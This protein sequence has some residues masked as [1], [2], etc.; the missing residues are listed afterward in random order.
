MSIQNSSLIPVNLSNTK[1]NDDNFNSSNKRDLHDGNI[2]YFTENIKLIEQDVDGGE[3]S[4]D[5][6]SGDE[7]SKSEHFS[8]TENIEH[9]NTITKCPLIIN[10]SFHLAYTSEL[11]NTSNCGWFGC[12]VASALGND[13]QPYIKFGHGGQHPQKFRMIDSATTGNVLNYGESFYIY[14]ETPKTYLHSS[15]SWTNKDRYDSR[16]VKT[17]GH[18]YIHWKGSGWGKYPVR[19]YRKTTYKYVKKYR[20][21]TKFWVYPYSGTG[22]KMGDI[23]HY[24]E[25]VIIGLDGNINGKKLT[26][27]SSSRAYAHSTPGSG[28]GFYFRKPIGTPCN[29]QVPLIINN[30]DY[31]IKK[32]TIRCDD[33]FDMYI[34]GRKYSGSGWKNTFTF[35]D[36]VLAN[37]NNGFNI[38]FRCYN[39]GGPAGLIACIELNNGSVYFTD[40]TWDAAVD[41]KNPNFFLNN[42]NNYGYGKEWGPPNVIG[43]NQKKELTWDGNKSTSRDSSFVD[44]KFSPF[45]KWIWAGKCFNKGYVYLKKTIGEPPKNTARCRHN[46]TFGEALCYLEK[47]PDL[48]KAF[49]PKDGSYNINDMVDKAQQHW[50]YFGCTVREN[51]EYTCSKPPETIGKFETKSCHDDN[52]IYSSNIR[53]I[54]NYRGTVR[55]LGECSKLAEDNRERVFGVTNGNQCY[56]SN[57]L[58]SA[59]QH[60]VAPGCSNMGK[61]G[62]FQVYHRKNPYIPLNAVIS[63]KNFTTSED[64]IEHFEHI[65]DEYKYNKKIYLFLTIIILIL[66]LFYYS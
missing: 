39:G 30:G 48:V 14:A 38:A 46:L 6:E 23:V 41:I 12:R 27:E 36:V 43:Y 11:N 51:R 47:Y 3:E 7:E 58:K 62:A 59:I 66:V 34:G 49:T 22:K 65:E 15:T 17:P 45:A 31:S 33:K 32:I 1:L 9:F 63:N 55:S 37:K 60:K 24:N 57:D 26:I 20:G 28:K 42:P 5:E 8:N 18:H 16:E 40:E 50:K 54:P 19:R 25:R 10:D 13:S 61:R 35:K 21:A 2:E 56:T 53:V 29:V 52:S 44:S 64:N 4:G